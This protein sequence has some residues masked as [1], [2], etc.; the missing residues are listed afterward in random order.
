M[1]HTHLLGMCKTVCRQTWMHAYL[2]VKHVE[3]CRH[4]QGH[5][6]LWETL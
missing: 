6:H 4:A 3:V 1:N 2:L 5:T